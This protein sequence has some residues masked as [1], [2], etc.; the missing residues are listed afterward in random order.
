[1]GKTKRRVFLFSLEE[2]NGR[3]DH[4]QFISSIVTAFC[5]YKIVFLVFTSAALGE[6]EFASAVLSAPVVC[7]TQMIF[8]Y[9]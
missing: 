1:M 3:Q 6:F 9:K 5:L 2:L 8:R 4:L 7:N